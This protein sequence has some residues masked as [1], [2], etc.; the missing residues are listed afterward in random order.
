MKIVKH[1][2]IFGLLIKGA[3]ETIQ[4]VAKYQKV[5][6]LSMLLSTLGASLLG[7]MLADKGVRI[8]GEDTI[9]ANQNF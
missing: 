3:I 4:N 8:A 6:F 1:L 9:T 5:V 2:E 7:N